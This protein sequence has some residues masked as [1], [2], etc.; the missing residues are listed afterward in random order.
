MPNAILKYNIILNS[1]LNISYNNNIILISWPRFVEIEEEKKTNKNQC[2]L[3]YKGLI[4]KIFFFYS[5]TYPKINYPCSIQLKNRLYEK[6]IPTDGQPNFENKIYYADNYYIYLY[7]IS[8]SRRRKLI[9][10]YKEVNTKHLYLLKFDVK[11]MVTHVVFFILIETGMH[12]NNLILADFDFINNTYEKPK[13]IYN[14]NDF[15]ILGNSYLNLNSEFAFLL[16]RDMVSGFILHISTG[17]LELI[18]TGNNIIRAYHSPFN[19]GYCMI[20][21]TAKNE[22]KFTQNFSPEIDLPNNVENGSKNTNNVNYINIFNFKCGDLTCFKLEKDEHIIDILFNAT[23]DYCFCAISL[24][25]SINIYNREMKFIISVNFN[26]K[27]SPYIISSLLFLDS[28]LIYSRNDSILYFYPYD[29]INQLIFRNNR[30]PIYISGILPDRFILVSITANSNIS[31]SDIT[32]PMINPLEPILIGYLDSPN[33][34]YDL[35]KQCVI[36]MFTNQISQK[37][38]DKLINKNLKEIAWLFIDDEK[39]T[40]QNLDIK[41]NLINENL[42]FEK[43]IENVFINK[44]FNDKLDIDDIIWKL[45]YDSN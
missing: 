17:N 34:D 30:K 3:I 25:S 24:I 22:Y 40:F 29:N 8:T 11:D 19:H 35:V 26:F 13:I 27:E 37:L 45:N 7:D 42:N 16:S 28:T 41:M 5:I 4:S 36:N 21:R 10:Y 31:I 38:I 18:K 12:R 23:S 32:S 2:T 39:S 43:I 33:I 14:I 1:L 9:N 20:F 6:Y 44:N 15:V